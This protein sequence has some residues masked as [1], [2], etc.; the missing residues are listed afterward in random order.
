[1]HLLEPMRMLSSKAKVFVVYWCGVSVI[2]TSL[3]IPKILLF[4]YLERFTLSA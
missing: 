3:R 2:Y 4:G 1:M